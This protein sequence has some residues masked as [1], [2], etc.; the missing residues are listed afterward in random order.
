MD[1]AHARPILQQGQAP[2]CPVPVLREGLMLEHFPE[3]S[4]FLKHF[5]NQC[6]ELY[7]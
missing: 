4:L 5:Q 7:Q 1:A 3:Y 2:G 6:S